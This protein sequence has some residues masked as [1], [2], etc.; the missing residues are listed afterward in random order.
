MLLQEQAPLDALVSVALRKDVMN[1]RARGNTSSWKAGENSKLRRV[2][3][4]L[5]TTSFNAP[6]RT[7]RYQ[8]RRTLL[9]SMQRRCSPNG[10]RV[11]GMG[12]PLSIV[13]DTLSGSGRLHPVTQGSHQTTTRH[14]EDATVLYK[15]S[16]CC[17]GRPN[18]IEPLQTRRPQ[19]S[20]QFI[21]SP[22]AKVACCT[23]CTSTKRARV[24]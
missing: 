8:D 1:E 23:R 4:Y 15:L 5:Y 3:L 22:W 17:S 7:V 14:G 6:I 9:F 24:H 19:R 21:M 11:L 16:G 10:T 20:P 13:L 18:A 2:I 12:L